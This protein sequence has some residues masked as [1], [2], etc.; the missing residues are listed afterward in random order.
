MLILDLSFV[1]F[2]GPVCVKTEESLFLFA[3]LTNDRPVRYFSPEMS[4]VPSF[5]SGPSQKPLLV[6]E[7]HIKREP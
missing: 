7:V 2:E 6:P 3:G 5:S 4:V 1:S